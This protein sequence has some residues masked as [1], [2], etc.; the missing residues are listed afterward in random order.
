MPCKCKSKKKQPNK[1]QSERWDVN[2]MVNGEGVA[3]DDTYNRLFALCLLWKGRHSD[4]QDRYWSDE[5]K[6]LQ[7]GIY[8]QVSQELHDA[9]Q[10]IFD[11]ET[12]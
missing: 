10:V 1:F 2:A 5:K 3:P 6:M 12:S 7:A 11:K 8:Q 4:I 9:L